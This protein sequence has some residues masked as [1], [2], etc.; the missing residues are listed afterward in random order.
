MSI[1]N[2]VQDIIKQLNC[3]QLIINE[4]QTGTACQQSS[5]SE[6]ITKWSMKCEHWY[7]QKKKNCI[8]YFCFKKQIINFLIRL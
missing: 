4:F 5:I 2:L 1:F 7:S 3:Y 6:L 8:H